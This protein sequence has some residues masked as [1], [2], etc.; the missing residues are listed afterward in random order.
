MSTKQQWKREAG[1]CLM[2]QA[3]MIGMPDAMRAIIAD[4]HADHPG[5]RRVR[6][7]LHEHA[8]HEPRWLE[9]VYLPEKETEAL[10]LL[11]TQV[12]YVL[13]HPQDEE[14]EEL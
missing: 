12:A 7:F 10:T 11:G 9:T 8:A 1:V 4:P 14:E 2:C 3:S 13:V 5:R 6:Q